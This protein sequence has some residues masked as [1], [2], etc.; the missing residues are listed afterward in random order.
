[1]HRLVTVRNGLGAVL[2]LVYAGELTVVH[3]N[4]LLTPAGIIVLPAL[5]FV[6]FCLLDG[7]V[8]RYKLSQAGLVL[9]HFALYGVLIT[10]LL[11]GE[12]QNYIHHPEDS[13]ITTLIR[14]QAGLYP[15]FSYHLLN[16]LAPKRPAAPIGLALMLCAGYVAILTPTRSFGLITAWETFSTAPLL[17]AFWSGLGLAALCIAFRRTAKSPPVRNKRILSITVALGIIACIPAVAAFVLLIIGMLTVG[18]FWLASRSI[19][20]SAAR[21]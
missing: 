21:L 20:Q 9:L 18:A 15:L 8:A 11:H 1:M 12:L 14:F 3:G 16:R 4:S 10:G 2:M 6:Y 5:Y 13:L 19:R 7:L 17:C